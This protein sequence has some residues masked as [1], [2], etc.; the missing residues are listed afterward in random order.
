MAK[1]KI[2][3]VDGPLAGQTESISVLHYKLTKF[4]EDRSKA[5]SYYRKDD[6]GQKL[7]EYKYSV[8]P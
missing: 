6:P 7:K 8:K 5:F 2:R 1:Y 4:P 3:F